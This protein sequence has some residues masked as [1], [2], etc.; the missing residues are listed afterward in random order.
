MDML[1]IFVF[2]AVAAVVVSL[3]SGII[4][5]VVDHEI[6]H[7]DSA[8]WM[9]WRVGLQGLAVVLLFMALQKAT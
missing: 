3:A 1:T 6:A 2:L 4:S 8:H 9:A 7:V 5:M